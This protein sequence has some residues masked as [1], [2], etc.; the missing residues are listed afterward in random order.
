MITAKQQSEMLDNPT[1]RRRALKAG[2]LAALS[3]LTGANMADAR[4]V[5]DGAPPDE[6]PLVNPRLRIAHLL[7]RAGFGVTKEQL[8]QFEAI[9]YEAT[10]D[11]LVNYEHIEDPIEERLASLDLDLAKP[12]H[13]KRWWL[14]RMMQTSRPLQEKMV[15]FWHGL[16]TSSLQKVGSPMLMLQQNE[17]FR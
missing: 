12:D 11:F 10:V 6:N 5:V 14:V 7:R 4:N 16:L 9:G 2:L 15:F 17:F 13:L 1:T 8:N 3:M